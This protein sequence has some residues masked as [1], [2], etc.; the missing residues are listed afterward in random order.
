ML[1][2]SHPATNAPAEGGTET[3]DID[4]SHI[5]TEEELNAMTKAE[6]LALAEEFV[7]ALQVTEANT[8]AEI[9]AAFMAAQAEQNATEEDPG[10]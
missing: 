2:R 6:I 4:Y 1:V 7:L 9:I 3:N 8:K 5:Y 10:E